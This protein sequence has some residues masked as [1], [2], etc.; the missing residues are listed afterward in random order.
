MFRRYLLLLPAI[1]LLFASCEEQKKRLSKKKNIVEKPFLIHVNHYFGESEAD[2]SFPIWFDD[3]LI[4]KNGIKQITRRIYPL[5][6]DTS[7]LAL[8]KEEKIYAF[9]ETGNVTDHTIRHYYD[10][11]VVGE[12]QF[13]YKKLKD[14]EGFA[15]VEI[16]HGSGDREQLEYTI[17]RKEQYSEKFLV[18]QDARN[19]NYLFC[20]TDEDLSGPLS[21]DSVFNPTSEDM[22]LI[23]SPRFPT[24]KYRV[25]NKVNE[26]DVRTLE[27]DSKTS[28][29]MEMH[30]DNNPFTKHRFIKY[31][32][33]GLCSGF[34]DSTFS[35]NKFLQARLSTFE[36]SLAQLP[37]RLVHRTK[38]ATSGTD[39]VQLETF[40]Y[41]FYE[42]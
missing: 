4:V 33:N 9:D 31:D 3:S 40:E 8:A 17:H 35:T 34:T 42:E 22:V 25:K 24:K 39:N 27:Y 29:I 2:V 23:G 6:A 11:M 41:E 10:G 30:F 28:Q 21:I 32:E 12:L 1:L 19:G 20:M 5:N 13:K 7:N 18:Y 14:E 26:F 38:R 37:I 15:Q 36:Y 16:A